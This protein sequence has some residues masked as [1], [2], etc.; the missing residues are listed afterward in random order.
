MGVGGGSAV[1]FG[2]VGF[3]TGFDSLSK[4]FTTFGACLLSESVSLLFSH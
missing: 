3:V 2:A 1:G 4:S